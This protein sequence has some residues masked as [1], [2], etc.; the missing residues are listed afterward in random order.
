VKPPVRVTNEAMF[1]YAFDESTSPE[2]LSIIHIHAGGL[3]DSGD[4]RAGWT[5]S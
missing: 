4:P 5:A 2:S 3:A 1:A